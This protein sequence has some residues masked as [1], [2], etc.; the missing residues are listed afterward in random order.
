MIH[1]FPKQAMDESR[2]EQVVKA[3]LRMERHVSGPNS[4]MTELSHA[5]LR[6]WLNCS[7]MNPWSAHIFLNILVQFHKLVRWLEKKYPLTEG[8]RSKV[9][10]P[11]RW[12]LVLL[13]KRKGERQI[14]SCKRGV[15]GKRSRLWTYDGNVACLVLRTLMEFL[16]Q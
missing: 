14:N 2:V 1:S 7:L 5:F 6:W 13:L 9:Y 12:A 11:D 16:N 4:F 10:T 8:G 3:S 15:K